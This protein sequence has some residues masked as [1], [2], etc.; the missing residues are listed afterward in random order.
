MIPSPLLGGPQEVRKVFRFQ[1]NGT[2]N[3]DFQ[4][5]SGAATTITR[6]GAGVFVITLPVTERYPV[7]IGVT[8]DVLGPAGG[9]ALNDQD[10]KAT[11]DGYVPSTGV[12]TVSVVDAGTAAAADPT[13]NSWV[14][15]EAIFCRMTL[16]APTGPVPA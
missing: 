4:V 10:V 8:G 9:S 3:P 2:S 15:V 13:D 7:L 12:L 1:I 16:L 5:P 11:V 6:S 14:F